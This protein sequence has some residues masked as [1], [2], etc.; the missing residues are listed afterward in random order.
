MAR[1]K[2][3]NRTK[4]VTQVSRHLHQGPIPD[5]NTLAG[6]NQ[7]VPNAAERIIAMA[8]AEALHRQQLEDNTLKANI[9]DRLSARTEIKLG[10]ILAFMLCMIVVLCGTYLAISGAQWPGVVLGSTGL[11]GIIVAYLKK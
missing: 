9:A 8:E 7:I 11:S 1:N 4:Q 2:Q 3:S 5:P 10:Q 6:Y